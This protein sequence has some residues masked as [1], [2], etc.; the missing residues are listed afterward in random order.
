MIDRL[1]LGVD[2]ADR[3]ASARAGTVTSARDA[4]WIDMVQFDVSAADRLWEGIPPAHGAPEW[5]D[6]VSG[7][8]ETASGPAEPHE[9]VDEPVVVEDMHKTA[10]DRPRRCRH[11]RMLGRVVA[12][13][14]AAA[15]TATVLGVAAAAAATTGIVATMASVVVPAIEEHVLLD[16]NDREAAVPAAPRSRESGGAPD[17]RPERQ[18]NDLAAAPPAAPATPTSP[19][20]ADAEPA[21]ASA[22]PAATAPTAETGSAPAPAATDPAPA[23]DPPTEPPSAAGPMESASSGPEPAKPPRVVEQ[24]ASDPPPA[25][26]QP[27]RDAQPDKG[28]RWSDRWVDADTCARHTCHGRGHYHGGGR[29][30]HRGARAEAVAEPVDHARPAHARLLG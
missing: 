8:I 25:T 2:R 17:T 1:R 12:I 22:S 6:D 30:G 24:P 15:T 20:P 11:G 19:Q 27:R 28:R 18:P 13:K 23:D 26:E 7:L 3:E 9:L 14:A 4:I 29:V 10:L 21:V 16:D 5:Y